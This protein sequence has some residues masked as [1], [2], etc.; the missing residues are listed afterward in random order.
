MVATDF[1]KKSLNEQ[2]R[3]IYSILGDKVE[4]V[5]KFLAAKV[6]EN[7][8]NDANIQWLTKPKVLWRFVSS[9]FIKRDIFKD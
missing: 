4:P 3:K 7:H 9:L 8:E 1:L 5:T 2:N 6:L